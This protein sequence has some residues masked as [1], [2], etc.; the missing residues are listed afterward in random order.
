MVAMAAEA[1][2]N[3][4]VEGALSVLRAL[5]SGRPELR[6]SDVAKA[7]AYPRYARIEQALVK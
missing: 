7:T 6:V 2:S 1:S 4:S 3:Q 5:T